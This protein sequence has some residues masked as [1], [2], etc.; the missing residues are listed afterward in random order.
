MSELICLGDSIT[1]CNHLFED[2][3][4]GNGYVR[5]LAKKFVSDSGSFSQMEKK[6]ASSRYN[7][8]LSASASANSITQ[9]RNYG[10]DGFTV[11][12]ILVRYPASTSH[13]P[14]LPSLLYW[15]ESMISV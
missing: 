4:L 3:P 8:S 1:D 10:A 9:V 13:F 11:A 2:Y 12:R 5:I 6:N 15:W 14:P 7:L